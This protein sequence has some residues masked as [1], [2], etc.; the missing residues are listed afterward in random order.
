MRGAWRQGL[1]SR[2]DIPA[3]RV[4]RPDYQRNRKLAFERGP[5][6]HWRFWGCTRISTTADH[7][8][9]VARGG[10]NGL[11]N[12]VGSCTH[13]NQLR[14]GAEFE[15]GTTYAFSQRMPTTTISP[16]LSDGEG[17]VADSS[18]AGTLYSSPTR[19]ET[20]VDDAEEH[21]PRAVREQHG[22]RRASF[23]RDLHAGG[24]VVRSVRPE[25]PREP[26][27]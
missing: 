6:C 2:A 26:G 8:V 5:E 11:D 25:L 10:G 12:L 18:S 19:F 22:V 13:C 7:L 1:G 24:H 23:R 15:G 14:R 21:V 17:F 27:R 4:H 9:P 20:F 16:A 3:P